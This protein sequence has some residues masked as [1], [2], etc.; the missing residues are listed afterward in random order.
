MFQLTDSPAVRQQKNIIQHNYFIT[1][2]P[3]HVCE[4]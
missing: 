2:E 1:F 4:S 3:Q